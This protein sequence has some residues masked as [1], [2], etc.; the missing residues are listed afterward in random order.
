MNTQNKLIQKLQNIIPSTR[1]KTNEPLANHTYIKIGGPADILVQTQNNQELVQVYRLALEYKIPTFFLGSGSN[2]IVSDQGIRGLVIK[3]RADSIKLTNFHG[4]IKSKN[5]QI[6]KVGLEV[7][8][9]VIT[10][11]LVRYS[12]D[13]GLS[14]LEFF[15]GIPGTVGGAIYNNSHYS[16][17]LIGDR[18]KSVKTLSRQGKEVSYDHQE[19]KFDYDYSIFQKN[20]ELILSAVFTLKPSDKIQLWEKATQYAKN[21]SLSQPLSTP[22]SGCM[23]KNIT[24]IQAARAG[25]HHTTS[26]GYLIDQAG[27]KG[28]HVGDAYVSE[29]HANFIVNR[30][31]ATAQ[32]VKKLVKE[33]QSKIRK[34]YRISIQPEVFFIGPILDHTP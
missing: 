34:K 7:D 25:I 23:F 22:N 30:G 8:S 1:V 33:I 17:Q 9:G 28:I 3:N 16:E 2:I 15:L 29:K 27:L 6:D 26:T 11:H 21:R 10:N 24:Q 20:H 4:D 5:I 14:G 18:V 32:D 12:I 31:N 13:Q 19:I